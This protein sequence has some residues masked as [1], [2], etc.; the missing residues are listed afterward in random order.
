MLDDSV[1]LENNIPESEETTESVEISDSDIPESDSGESELSKEENAALMDISSLPGVGPVTTKK[2]QDVGIYTILDIAVR[3]PTDIA[4]ATNFE[5]DKAV[6]LCN[7]A[8]L[9]LVEIGKFDKDFVSATEI[10]DRRQKIERIST[11]SSNLDELLIGGVETQA[12]TEFYG[13]YGSGKTQICHTLC[14]NVQLPVE[15]GGLNGGAIYIDT[16]NTFR[17]ERLRDIAIERGMDPDEAL[18]KI[19]VAKAF[20]SSH[21]ELL[22]GELGKVIES[23]NAR[24]VIVDS[25]MGH[26]RSEFLGRGTLATR[27]HRLNRFMHLLTRTAETRNVAVVM[28]NQVMS[29][30]DAFFGDPTR[31]VG[32]HVVAHTS[33]YRLYLRKSGKNRIAK[34]K[35]SPYHPEHEAV[36]TLNERGVDDPVDAKSKKK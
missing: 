11:G 5:T 16:E 13:E 23:S 34:M 6:E 22:V 29:A 35:D 32:G 20:T 33:T 36:F 24:L 18:S 7:K 8:R 15:N 3:G 1:D 21:Q 12:V 30:P 2:L 10:Y 14:L 25:L 27:Q 17:P 19:I 31:P 28:T 9:K 26:Y 4:D